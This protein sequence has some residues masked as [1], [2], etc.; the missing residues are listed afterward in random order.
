M[1]KLAGVGEPMTVEQSVGLVGMHETEA[2]HDS[3]GL[4]SIATSVCNGDFLENP[5]RKRTG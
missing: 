2:F 1:E 4:P 3:K 5:S